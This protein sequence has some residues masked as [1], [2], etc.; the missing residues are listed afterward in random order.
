VV[1]AVDAARR[2]E[3]LPTGLTPPVDRLL[4]SEYLYTFPDGCAPVEDGQTSSGICRLGD[5]TS[6]RSIVVFGDSHAQMW[7]PMILEMA[8]RDRWAVIPLVKS[9]CNPSMW[10]GRGYPGT[11]SVALRQ[12]HT[13]YGWASREARGLR[14][15][16][17]LM[18]GCCAGAVEA[19][20]A[21]TIRA[22]KELTARVRGVSRRVILLGDPEGV[23]QQP[24]DCLL[25]RNATMRK[26]TTRQS[27]I[28]F[29][30]NDDLAALSKTT[31]Y[32]FLNSRGWFCFEHQCPM[33]IGRTIVYRDTGHI[34]P[35][36]ASTLLAPFRAAFMRCVRTNCPR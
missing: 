10:I 2:G 13:W 25:G 20:A 34:T 22:Y 1:A 18:T 30:L 35:P 33:V 24:V 7:M 27:D 17:V 36:Y 11:L 32:R 14:P 8:R 9:G 3:K 19:T 5:A 21:D 28:H 23:D 26:C 12:C 16:V 15:D 31:G 29:A 6:R 4:D